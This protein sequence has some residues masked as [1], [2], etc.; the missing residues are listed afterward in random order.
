M[1]KYVLYRYTTERGDGYIVSTQ[2]HFGEKQARANEMKEIV[3]RTVLAEGDDLG[4]L[5]Q[6]KQLAQGENK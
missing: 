6:M 4:V 3:T 2:L 1:S 5:Y